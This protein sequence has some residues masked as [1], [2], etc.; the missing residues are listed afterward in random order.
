MVGS[1]I[2]ARYTVVDHT[3]FDPATLA[4]AG[5][6]IDGQPVLMNREY[7]GAD[8]RIVLGFVEPHFMAGFSGGYKGV[9]PGVADIGSI[10]RYHDAQRSGIRGA[11][12]ACWR[13]TRRRRGSGTTARSLPVDFC[14][15]VTLNRRR[16]IRGSTAVRSSRRTKRAA[17]SRRRT[18]MVACER[19]VANRRHDQQRIPARSESVSG[20]QGHVG[21]GADRGSRRLHRDGGTLQR[22]L[23]RAR[24]F[25]D[26]CS[27]ITARRGPCST[28]SCLPDSRC[29]T[30]GRRSCWRACC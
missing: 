14:V 13:A 3:A 11:P 18:A 28:R 10:M 22:R 30:N 26:A 5:T 20:R 9:F 7:V 21:G 12:G 25:Q 6:G 24:Q 17:H 2:A 29:T 16:E 15:N 19:P 23:P 8:R 4:P 1:A 27:S